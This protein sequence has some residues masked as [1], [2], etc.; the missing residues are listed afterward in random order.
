VELENL[1]DDFRKQ[2][3]GITAISYDSQKILREFADRKHITFPLLSDVDAEVIKQFGILNHNVP[4]NN[5]NYGIPFPGQYIVDQNGIVLSKYFE[6]NH[7]ERVTRES[8]L[9]RNTDWKHGS[10][11]K[12]ETNELIIEYSANQTIL[13][14]L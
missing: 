3:L 6:N 11:G 10:S 1:K 13:N 5:K 4:K 14:Q 7:R 12:I 8:V 2:G 9:I